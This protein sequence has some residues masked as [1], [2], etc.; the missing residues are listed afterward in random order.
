MRDQLPRRFSAWRHP[1]GIVESYR[2]ADKHSV[3]DN[4][5]RRMGKHVRHP[6]STPVVDAGLERDFMSAAVAGGEFRRTPTV[7]CRSPRVP[8]ARSVGG[9]GRRRRVCPNVLPGNGDE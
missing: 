4:G 6:E 9:T 8:R 3:L 1:E 7:H 5:D 2:L